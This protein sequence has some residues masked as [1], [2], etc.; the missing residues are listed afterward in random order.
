MTNI[1]FASLVDLAAW[2][3]THGITRD[4]W[5]EE[6]AKTL[7]DLWAE[8][9]RGET[10]FTDD[11]PLRLVAV[12]QVRVRRGDK[13]LVELEQEFA[14]GRR[15]ARNRRPSEKIKA[16]ES[17]LEAARRCLG[18]ELGLEMP[19]VVVSED[20]ET[21]ATVIDS[22]SYPGLPT[23]YTFYTYDVRAD[24]LPE[25]DFWRENTAEGDPIRRHFWGWRSQAS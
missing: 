8:Y 21:T 7:A 24:A 16:G 19:D 18:E 2:L 5:G 20:V 11:P 14:D 15:R 6:G 9:Q 1:P 4:G 17:P 25:G 3:D 13:V 22:P 10:T 23:R 12:A